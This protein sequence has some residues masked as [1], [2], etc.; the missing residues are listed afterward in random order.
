ML[1]STIRHLVS[2]L[3]AC[4]VTAFGLAAHAEVITYQ[5]TAEISHFDDRTGVFAEA[6]IDD[7]TVTGTFY[8]DTETGAIVTRD[9]Y[10]A[11]VTDDAGINVDGA[12]INWL[13]AQSESRIIVRDG[14]GTDAFK[15]ETYGTAEDVNGTDIDY[16]NQYVQFFRGAGDPFDDTSIPDS[17]SLDD[18]IASQYYLHVMEGGQFSYMWGTI[19]SLSAVHSTGVPELGGQSAP[20]GIVLLAGS[21]LIATGRRRQG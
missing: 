21:A 6:G 13:D 3:G 18:F 14:D 12:D 10:A 8:Y 5:F 11:Y 2:G 16:A 15:E 7:S 4:A 9:G 17:L 20:L 19:T 1:R